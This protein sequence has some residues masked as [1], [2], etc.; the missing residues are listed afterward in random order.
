MRDTIKEPKEIGN[1]TKQTFYEVD[2]RN[3]R[4]IDESDFDIKNL[5]QDY[6][7]NDGTFEQLVNSLIVDGPKEAMKGFRNK[8]NLEI[9]H[10][11][12]GHTRTK[13]AAEVFKRTGKVI[14]FRIFLVPTRNYKKKDFIWDMY[15]SNTQ[16][17][18]NILEVAEM[19]KLL[20]KEGDSKTTIAKKMNCHTN[21]ISNMLIVSDSPKR[22]R[23]AI[24]EGVV[25]YST[26]VNL[27]K[28]NIDPQDALEKLESAL[29]LAKLEKK[30]KSNEVEDETDGEKK[31]KITKTHINKVE[32]RVDSSKELV[33]VFKANIDNKKVVS[34]QHLYSI[35][36][37][38]VEN[39]ITRA[40]L[41]NILFVS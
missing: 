35:L 12:S 23:D 32:N 1:E 33:A 7:K 36:K 41:E 17:E 22:M 20:I 34:D 18:M 11:I 2:F 9:W 28:N 39:K 37:R 19:I 5:R 26:V 38:I 31:V 3:I 21:F 14:R 4:P 6:G 16:R 25:S 24:R 15:L 10:T 30:A 40:Q 8:D 29:G 13:A 27:L